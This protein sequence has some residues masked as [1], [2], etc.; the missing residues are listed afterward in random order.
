MNQI[1]IGPYKEKLNKIMITM[2]IIIKQPYSPG[3]KTILKSDNLVKKCC[4]LNILY[5]HL[6]IFCCD[7]PA[8]L[9]S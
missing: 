6:Y 9:Q 2:T 7:N 8:Y 4:D 3:L 1:I 5:G